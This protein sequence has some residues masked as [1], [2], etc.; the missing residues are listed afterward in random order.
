MLEMQNHSYLLKCN[1]ISN[2]LM[3]QREKQTNK[4]GRIQGHCKPNYLKEMLPIFRNSYHMRLL[5]SYPELNE[6]KS[7]VAFC[8]FMFCFELIYLRLLFLSQRHFFLPLSDASAE[9]P[10]RACL[11]SQGHQHEVSLFLTTLMQN[12][13]T[14]Q[15]RTNE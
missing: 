14:Q 9:I 6:I 11:W 3:P 15:N 5:M 8:C 4:V 12:K 10:S 7:Y 2:H 1:S 13:Q